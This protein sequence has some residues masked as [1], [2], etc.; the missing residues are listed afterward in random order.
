MRMK[1]ICSR[2]GLTDR[3]VRLYIDSG[4]LSPKEEISYTGRRSIMFSEED[5]K[6]LEVIATLRQAGFSLADIRTMQSDPACTPDI[7][8]RHRQT[9][10]T[11]IDE[12]R[13]ILEKLSRIETDRP[14]PCRDIAAVL[15]TD[16]FRT[17]SIP[18]E[19]SALHPKD[20]K[21]LIHSR[22]PSILALLLTV[23]SL[24]T[25]LPKAV[26]TAFATMKILSGG[27]FI[28]EYGMPEEGLLPFLPLFG[29]VLLI[30]TAA[31]LLLIRTLGGRR[32][33]LAVSASLTAAAVLLLL[34][35]PETVGKQLFLFEFIGY[36][37]SFMYGIFYNTSAA[38]DAFIRSLKFIPLLGTAILAAVSIW[39][40][41]DLPKE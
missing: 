19:D 33:L 29:A 9:L 24:S 17:I 23:F 41:K 36:R 30:L 12:K 16:S 6:T 22:I 34:F 35:L 40:E 1:E 26:K 31:V 18:K 37:Y 20:F 3:A 5:A 8:I 39:R 14:L 7:L 15:R 2:T 32:P 4:L 38:F 21:R 11:E 28:L 10:S 13:R 25:L 27:G